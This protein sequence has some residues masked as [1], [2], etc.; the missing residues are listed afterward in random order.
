[1]IEQPKILKNDTDSP[2][3][4]HPA[5][6]RKVGYVLA[7]HENQTARRLERHKKKPQKR[8]FSGP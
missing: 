1:M 8:R 7:E 5:A 3:K 2:P 4:S 6:W